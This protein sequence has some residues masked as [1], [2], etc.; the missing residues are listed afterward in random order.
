[1]KLYSQEMVMLTSQCDAVGYVRPGA[2]LTVLQEASGFHS[3]ELGMGRPVLLERGCA[4]IITRM[5]VRMRRYPRVEEKVRVETYPTP[6]HH[7]FFPR[8]F[9]VLDGA[10]DV[11]AEANSLWTLLDLQNRKMADP[12]FVKAKLPDNSDLPP[13]FGLPATARP[14]DA[15]ARESVRTPVYTDLDVNGHVNNTRYLDWCCD[16]LGI[17]TLK[18]QRM[19]RFAVNYSHEILPEA[20]VRL[21]LRRD[22]NRFS[23]C[24]SEG[25]TRYFDLCGEMGEEQTEG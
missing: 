21:D 22:G 6:M 8:S 24:G 14:L 13:V 10:G 2:L 12:A 17:E 23:F 19:M 15:E 1:M 5:E 20:S 16:A 3:A 4:W 9:R 18:H 11:L 25:D 7:W